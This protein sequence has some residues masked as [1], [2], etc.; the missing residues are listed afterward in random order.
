MLTSDRI[1]ELEVRGPSAE[2]GVVWG[3][4]VPSPT[5]ERFREGI[6][7]PPRIFFDFQVQNDEIWCI[8]GAIFTVRLPVLHTK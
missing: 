3:V 6:V 5:G 4:G 2:V 8:L 7:S 1:I